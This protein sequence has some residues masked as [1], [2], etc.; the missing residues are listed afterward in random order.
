M[1]DHRL[2]GQKLGDYT[3]QSRLGQGGMAEVFK[4][5]DENLQRYAALKV[6]EPRST[7]MDDEAEYRERFMR[8]ARA[9]ARLHHPRVVGVY[10]FG[11]TEDDNL[12][13]MAM[14][15]IEGQDLR[16]IL[17]DYN[18]ETKR[19]PTSELL[20]IM[21]DI[22][23]ALDYAHSQG[24]VHRDVKPSNIMV[25]GDGHAVLTDFGLALSATEGTLG[26]TFGSVHYIA[27]EQAV[28]SAAATAQSDLYSLGIVLF[29][30][31]TG[32]VPFDDVS[33]MSVALKHIQEPPP[34]PTMINPDIPPQVE[35]VVMKALDK[36]PHNRFASGSAFIRAL[37]AAIATAEEDTENLDNQPPF[38]P[39]NDDDDDDAL[40]GTS[41]RK[42]TRQVHPPAGV[43][44]RAILGD[45]EDD[46]HAQIDTALGVPVGRVNAPSSVGVGVLD[47]DE[48]IP[49]RQ[50]EPSAANMTQ[51]QQAA[52]DRR[53][54][55][56]LIAA[57]GV[58][59]VA[60]VAVV[61][62]M[63]SQ[64]NNNSLFAQTSTHLGIVSETQLALAT[65]TAIQNAVFAGETST[66][67]SE[68]AVSETGVAIA[69]L[70]EAARPTETSTPTPTDLSTD[71]PTLTFTPT[72]THTLTPSLTPTP[73]NTPTHTL[74]PTLTPSATFTASLTPTPGIDAAPTEPQ[75][76]LRYDGRSVVI[77]NRNNAGDIELFRLVFEQQDGDDLM[78]FE[79]EDFLRGEIVL[80][81]RSCA[82]LWVNRFTE[83]PAD[84]FPAE[85]CQSRRAFLQTTRTFWISE[86][87]GATFR[88]IRNGRTLGVCPAVNSNDENDN[89]CV[90]D[91]R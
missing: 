67:N 53:G 21:R 83:L 4:G 8:E 43:N 17:K 73:T 29:E 58:I 34:P 91:I 22:A 10:Q 30:I 7:P 55:G 19:L 6:I 89:R 27:P 82:Q 11:K 49:R 14:V 48:D 25:T 52:S 33:A 41:P 50:T 5:Y 71:T 63:S 56:L 46:A 32:R 16:H 76:L 18:R 39:L 72:D 37:E 13:Y 35:A 85:I 80:P 69:A 61:L 62:L 45:Y 51:T 84:E 44:A 23:A 38:V 90:V 47:L 59:L 88:V 26:N 1:A 77:Y 31:L 3:I 57:I 79:G 86:T 74:T 12:F 87:P 70:T 2:I 15:F 20:R 36:D 66:A 64:N 9:I 75:L 81:Q 60:I 78:V 24:V 28:S 42:P 65:L 68:A 54:G 40:G